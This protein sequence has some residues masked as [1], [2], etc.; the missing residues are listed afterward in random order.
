MNRFNNFAVT[1]S[2]VRRFDHREI[3]EEDIE[4]SIPE[5]IGIYDQH[6]S[7]N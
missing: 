1:N 5:E 4:E 7:N 3:Y 2:D 6:S